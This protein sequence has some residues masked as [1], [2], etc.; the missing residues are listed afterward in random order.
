MEPESSFLDFWN[1]LEPTFRRAV[2]FRVLKV[3]GRPLEDFA[4]DGRALDAVAKA[5]DPHTAGLIERLYRSWRES[6]L[7]EAWRLS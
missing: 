5:M 3:L 6:R 1:Q 2:E 7:Q 4:R